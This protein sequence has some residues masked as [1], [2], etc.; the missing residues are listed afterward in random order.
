[1]CRIL[2]PV[3]D[4]KAALCAVRRATRARGGQAVTEVVLLSVQPPLE[5]GRVRAFR[6]EEELK[7]LEYRRAERLLS[8]PRELLR[9]DGVR[10]RVQVCIG[11]PAASIARV[12]CNCGCDAIWLG[13]PRSSWW[14][15]LRMAALARR[16]VGVADVPVALVN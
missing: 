10:C 15:R 8:G 6:S 16:I 2:V 9:A 11:D 7:A 12:A 13:A 3:D 14:E 4:A 1:M 5:W